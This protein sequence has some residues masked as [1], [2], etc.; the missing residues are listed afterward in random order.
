MF[1]DP[2]RPIDRRQRNL[3][4]WHQPEAVTFVTF[5]LADAIPAQ[6]LT[7]WVDDRRRWLLAR[8]LS[9]EGDLAATL[10]LLPD[11]QRKAYL[12]EFGRRFHEL[13]DAGHGSCVLKDPHCSEVV[14][15]ALKHFDG[16]RYHLGRYV[17]M[18]NH[19]HLLVSPMEEHGL[20]A[21]LKSWKGFTAREINRLNG[22]SGQVWQ[23]ESFDHLVRHAGSLEAFVR[24]I[25][26]NPR[27]AKLL[28]GEFRL[29]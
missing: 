19:V 28:E 1:L 7:R 27:K 5:R 8:G 13:L 4:H 29:G 18:P 23:H 24:Y 9:A 14:E 16:I 2:E 21:I 6:A 17:V 20:S 10:A 22:T 15:D 11:E 26:E 25:E 3:P 12:R